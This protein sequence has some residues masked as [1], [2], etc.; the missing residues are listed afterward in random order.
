MEH[1]LFR[2]L[3]RIRQN[4]LLYLVFPSAKH[5][6][7]EHSLGVVQTSEQ[8]LQHLLINS[9]TSL[10]KSIPGVR[11]LAEAGAGEAVDF[12]DVPRD[13]LRQ[14]FRVTRLAALVH[15]LGHGPFSHT[16]DSFA[17]RVEEVKAILAAESALVPIRGLAGVLD[18]PRK[19]KPRKRVEHEHVSCIL[20]ANIWADLQARGKVERDEEGQIPAAVTAVL[21]GESDGFPVGAIEPYLRL[22]TD[23]ISSAPADA[24][25]MDYLER[26]SRAV[27]VSYGLYDRNRLLSSMLVYHD[28]DALRLGFKRSG[29]R[30]VENFVQARFELFAQVYFHKTN[31]STEQILRRIAELASDSAT[32]AVPDLKSLTDAYLRLSDERFL[33]LLLGGKDGPLQIE[34]ENVHRLAERIASRRLWKRVYEGDTEGAQKIADGLAGEFPDLIKVSRADPD[35]GK[36]LEKG[37]A[38]LERQGEDGV[39]VAQ[40]GGSWIA[41]SHVIA[42]L[43]TQATAIGRLYYTGEDPSQAREIRNRARTYADQFNLKLDV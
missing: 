26:D 40:A 8:M 31:Q 25:R 14:I 42:A 35:A 30:A 19:G 43:A 28:G 36:D 21:T 17:P 15:D 29:L 4:G 9:A 6:R 3:H 34:D 23:L 33:D 5:S 13:D 24:D 27:G 22:I 20:F 2:R 10:H 7:F 39:Y 1:P 37:A 32:M 12:Q 18:K 38:L 41:E 11:P 16:F